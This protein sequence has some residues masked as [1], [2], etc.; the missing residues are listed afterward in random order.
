MTAMPLPPDHV[1]TTDLYGQ[2]ILIRTEI[3]E[4]KADTRVIAATGQLVRADVADHETR[5][6]ELQAAVPVKLSDRLA[7]VERWQVRAGAVIA[8]I[9][10]VAGVFSG[11]LSSLLFRVH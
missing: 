10:A 3:A 1:T 11:Y 4:V 5:I 7:A 8:L 9:A 6:R 2:L